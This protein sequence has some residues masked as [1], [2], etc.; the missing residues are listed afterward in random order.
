[1]PD[2]RLHRRTFGGLDANTDFVSMMRSAMPELPDDAEP[3][4]VDA[5]VELTELTQD[6]DVNTA[7]RPGWT[8]HPSMTCARR[9]E[10]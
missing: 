7:A 10:T 2:H 1:M 3:E 4:Q 9:R 5:G 6:P 8:G